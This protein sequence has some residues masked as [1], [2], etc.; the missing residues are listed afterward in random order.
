MTA[1][2][3]VHPGNILRRELA[4]R[5]LSADDL[6]SALGVP[7][8]RIIDILNGKDALLP[9]MTPHLACYFGNSPSF[10]ANLQATY[11]LAVA[12]RDMAVALS[13]ETGS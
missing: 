4:A 11:E 2:I 12:A 7:V 9:N 13:V 8:G 6:A 3:P 5:G 1:M 10:W